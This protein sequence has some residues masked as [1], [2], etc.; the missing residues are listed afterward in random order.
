MKALKWTFLLAGIALFA[1]SFKLPAIRE[2]A[3][4]GASGSTVAGYFCAFLALVRPWGKEG[5]TLLQSDALTYFSVLI[6]G[7]INPVFVLALVVLLVRPASRLNWVFRGLLPV[8]FVFCWVVLQKIQFYGFH[9]HLYTGFYVWMAGILL[10][11][12]SDL[13]VKRRT[14]STI[15]GTP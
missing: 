4:S 5:L 12:F 9:F 6:S 13:W 2:V 1:V 7:W 15:A 11:I 14:T 10:A 3:Q 8:M